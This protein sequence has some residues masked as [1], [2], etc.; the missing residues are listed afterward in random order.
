[1][2]LSVEGLL[3]LRVALCYWGLGFGF[4]T[5]PGQAPGEGARETPSGEP[6]GQSLDLGADITATEAQLGEG[7]SGGALLGSFSMLLD[8]A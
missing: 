7:G 3:P 6:L 1:M 2:P 8:D 5:F 4:D